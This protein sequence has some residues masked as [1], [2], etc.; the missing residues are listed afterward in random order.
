MLRRPSVH[1]DSLRGSSV[2]IGT[3]QRRLA[4]PLRKDDTHKSRSVNDFLPLVV[5]PVCSWLLFFFSAAFLLVWLWLASLLC[6]LARLASPR[7]LAC[8]C[9]S[10]PPP[11][12]SVSPYP[13]HGPWRLWAW[14]TSS[15]THE[16]SA[17]PAILLLC[18]SFPFLT[19]PTSFGPWLRG[20]GLSCGLWPDS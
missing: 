14:A 19:P 15:S 4:W 1:L 9:C 5:L 10:C 20:F 8:E 13:S 2:K 11:L 3:I 18:S 7:P 16:T 17:H 12:V 6:P